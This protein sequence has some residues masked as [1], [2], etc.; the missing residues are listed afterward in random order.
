MDVARLEGEED[1]AKFGGE[2]D[3]F[4]A[5]QSVKRSSVMTNV[6]SAVGLRSDQQQRIGRFSPADR[7]KAR[8]ALTRLGFGTRRISAQVNKR[9]QQQRVG[10]R[11]R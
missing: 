6:L 2:L 11:G 9:R 8:Q 4:P 10:M 1:C 3:G 5:F 7:E